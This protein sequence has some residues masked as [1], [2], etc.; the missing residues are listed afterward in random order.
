MIGR[1]LYEIS[2]SYYNVILSCV[3]GAPIEF[4]HTEDYI[5]LENIV[6]DISNI[7][8]RPIIGSSWDILDNMRNT[9]NITTGDGTIILI[10]SRVD[11]GEK[12][13]FVGLTKL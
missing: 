3:T 8:G 11:P 12:E 13:M 2:D 4:S 9:V 10:W 7:I 5:Y 1:T 6:G